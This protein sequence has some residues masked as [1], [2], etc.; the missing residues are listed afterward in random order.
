MQSLSKKFFLITML[1]ISKHCTTAFIE[2]PE[3][4]DPLNTCIAQTNS[5]WGDVHSPITII[6]HSVITD[7]S[8]GFNRSIILESLKSHWGK[9]CIGTFFASYIWILYQIRF[10]CLLMKQ[11]NAWCNWK[12]VVPLHHL[13]LSAHQ[14]LMTQLKF[15]IGKKYSQ[16]NIHH[17]RCDLSTLFIHDIHEELA[18][19]QTYLKWQE[20]IQSLYCSRFFHFPF[21]PT[22]IEE[23]IT[24]LHFILDLFVTS[25]AEKM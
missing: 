23:K 11:H 13:Q 24:R 21:N 4:F 2:I 1:I 16:K 5:S 22:I 3:K 6:Q 14:D 17:A 18:T 12:N 25:Q 8:K 7:F 20:T 19:F 10:T 9:I 15:D